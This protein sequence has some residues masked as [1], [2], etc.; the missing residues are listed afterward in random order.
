MARTTAPLVSYNNLLVGST[1]TFST[2][3]AT[4]SHPENVLNSVTYDY[5]TT[6]AGG[7]NWIAFDLGSAQQIDCFGIAAHTLASTGSTVQIQ[8]D[9]GAGWVDAATGDLS[10]Q[11]DWTIFTKFS[12]PITAQNWRVYITNSTEAVSIGVIHAGPLLE[13]ERN[14]YQGHKP[15]LFG[16]VVKIKVNR[17]NTGRILG[18]S[19][20]KSGAVTTADFTNITASWLRSDLYEFI[21]WFNDGK[22]F[23]WGWYVDRFNIDSAYCWRN[24]REAM[25]K[26]TGPGDLMSASFDIRGYRDGEIPDEVFRDALVS[27][28]IYPAVISD[29]LTNAISVI[30]GVAKDLSITA[31]GQGEDELDLNGLLAAGNLRNVRITAA[32]QTEDDQVDLSGLLTDGD[33]RNVRIT[34]ADQTETDEIDLDGSLTA[35]TI[36][37]ARVTAPDQTESDQIDLSGN[38]LGGTLT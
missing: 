1:V 3:R 2:S 34:A 6:L 9:V 5:W 4:D 12:T 20:I 32:D 33:I 30:G 10:G 37:L 26:N 14:I 13:F 27:T 7:T 16:D 21:Q 25:I 28:T 38:L 31:G 36:R 8:Y 17:S 23:W 35:G 15:I 24:R 11:G 18:S 29:G 19:T 22:P